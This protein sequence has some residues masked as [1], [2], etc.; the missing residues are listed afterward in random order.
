MDMHGI[1]AI[2]TSKREFQGKKGKECTA[3]KGKRLEEIP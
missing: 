2:P 1:V 3:Q